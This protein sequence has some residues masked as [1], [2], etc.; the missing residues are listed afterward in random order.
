MPSR[1]GQWDEQQIRLGASFL[2]SKPWGDFQESIG[3]LVHYLKGDG[4]SCLLIKKHTPLGDYLFAP[5][6]PTTA[7]SKELP[8]ALE[9][10]KK[11]AKDSNVGWVR[12]EPRSK[13]GSLDDQ[14]SHLKQFGAKP[15]PHNVEPATTRI[16]SLEPDLDKL[17]ASI[18]AT[19]RSLIRKNQSEA[20]V[21]FRTSL[22]P[23]DI[24]IFASMLETVARRN[25]VNFFSKDYF[26]NQAKIL[27]PDGMMRLE[28]AMINSKP[29]AAIVVHDYGTNSSYTYAASL[30]EAR[31]KSASALLVWQALVNA[32]NRGIQTFDLFGI[33][34]TDASSNHPWQGFS[35]FKQK[36]GGE[37]LQMAGTWDIPLNSRY[38]V[39]KVARRIKKAL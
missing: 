29:V 10:I 11:F 24:I 9:A 8:V 1:S 30:P 26:L 2:Q 16:I 31:D 3:N 12:L 19:T 23:E 6:G 13:S 4:W 32:K 22:D 7:S 15:S 5:Y 21:T 33:A 39:Y 27:I 35:S 28:F 14:I 37:V 20:A 25:K 36:F 18:S 34:P 17:L 38:Q